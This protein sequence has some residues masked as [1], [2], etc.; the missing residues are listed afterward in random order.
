MRGQ[1]RPPGPA[2][3]A[4]VAAGVA[5]V[6]GTGHAAVSAYWLAG[7]TALLDTIG[8]S[9]EQWARDRSGTTVAA[10]A[11]VVA[12]KFGAA[13]LGPLVAAA[14][15]PSAPRWLARPARWRVVRPLA[16]LAAAVLVLYGG[17]LTVVGLAVEAGIVSAAP[18]ADERAL[19]W[20]AWLWDPWFLAW[21]LA[22]TATLRWS[23]PTRT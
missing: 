19:A 21:G 14:A 23:R 11:A 6:L 20:H 13:A 3:R 10:L 15:H 8:G 18:D 22:L 2:G 16:W 1:S 7:G 5:L 12:V 4:D 17:L 9:I